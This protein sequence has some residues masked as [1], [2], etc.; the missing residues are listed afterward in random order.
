M[1]GQFTWHRLGLLIR[2]DIISD[3]RSVLTGSAVLAVIMLL[4]AIP[5]VGLGHIDHAYYFGWFAGTLIIW[6]TVAASEAFKE[7]H[8]KTKNERYLLLP[9]SALEKTIA[10]ILNVTVLFVPYLLLFITLVSLITEGLN[11]LVFGRYNGLF[12]PFDPQIWEL[13]GVFLVLQSLFFLGG[14]WFRNLHWF[15]TVL[16]VFT[17]AIGTGVLVFISFRI[18]YADYFIGLLTPSPGFFVVMTNTLSANIDL[19]HTTLSLLKILY[20]SVV[21]PFCWFVAWLRVKETQVSH[22]V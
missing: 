20:F 7:L 9:A 12:N 2:N 1:N 13:I 19:Y 14:A 8:D 21:A 18:F 10:R 11:L 15:K 4:I 22:G 5:S 3:Y 6:G 16:S 17:I